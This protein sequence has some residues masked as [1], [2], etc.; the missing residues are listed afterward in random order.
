MPVESSGAHI[1]KQTLVVHVWVSFQCECKLQSLR[2]RIKM[3]C[4]T[5]NSQKTP[6]KD[7]H[8]NSAAQVSVR[9][10]QPVSSRGAHSLT[11]KALTLIGGLGALADWNWRAM[12]VKS[13]SIHMVGMV[14]YIIYVSA[15]IP[16]APCRQ[17]AHLYSRNRIVYIEFLSLSRVYVILGCILAAR[18]SSNIMLSRVFSGVV[19]ENVQQVCDSGHK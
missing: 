2:G 17:R 3:K 9:Y 4:F 11:R 10:N 6:A 16:G 15:P 18:L 1:N 12:Q 7:K 14:L 13:A 5:L 8:N 19:K